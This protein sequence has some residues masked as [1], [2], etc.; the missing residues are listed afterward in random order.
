VSDT[1]TELPDPVGRPVSVEPPAEEHHPPRWA[2]LT[3]VAVVA[4][5][6]CTNIANAT[7]ATLVDNDTP[8]PGLLLLLSARNRYLAFALGADISIVAYAV[9]GFVRIALAFAVC[10]LIGRAYSAQA[11]GWFKKYLGFTDEAE[12]AFDRGF[13][14]A[15]WALIP[16]FAGSNIV[17]VLTGVRRTPVRKLAVLLTIGIVGRL[18]FVWWLSRFFDD[19]L[20]SFLTFT[21]RYQ[22]WLL[23]A[24][25]AAVVLVN[26]R[27]VRRR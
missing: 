13:E 8:N 15:E 2:P 6:V 27:N 3:L 22:W 9:I 1:G 23:G 5:V 19:E 26:L 10:H 25:I 17:A 7:W 12:V 20:D 4:L 24:S 21:T 18:T 11:T 16:I 14:K